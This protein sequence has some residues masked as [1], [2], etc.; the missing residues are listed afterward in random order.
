MARAIIMASGLG[1]RMRPLTNVKPKPLIEVLG[2][3]MIET[4]IE[5]LQTAG[6]E[7]IYVVVGYLK[8]KFNY[9]TK[10]YKNL[11]LIENP[12]YSTVNNI[13]SIYYARDVLK[14]GDTFI[15]EADLYFTNK[16][17]FCEKLKNSCYFGKFVDG[18]SS[19][20]VF[21]LDDGGLISRV[22]KGGT[23]CYNMVGISYFTAQDALV[24]SKKIEEAYNSEGY[25]S[26]YWDEVVDRNLF[27]L[28]LG[29]H[30]VQKH[31]IFEIDTVEELNEINNMGERYF[32][33]T[34]SN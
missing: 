6:V 34:K 20:W 8:E 26:L 17:L 1:T 12:D 25:E 29:I 5:G 15:C 19:D 14:Q 11:S 33:N 27:A 9:L 30:P 22:G 7:H 18:Y 31:D 13:S 21:D 23:N 10:K 28:K 3:P 24:L 32:E 4:V 2:K 16:N